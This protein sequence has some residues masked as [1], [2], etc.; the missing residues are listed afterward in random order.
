MG[1]IYRQIIS[2]EFQRCHSLFN[3]GGGSPKIN[4]IGLHFTRYL[5]CVLQEDMVEVFS[6]NTS[7]YQ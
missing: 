3:I 1:N 7:Q 2:A 4:M 6:S 5:E